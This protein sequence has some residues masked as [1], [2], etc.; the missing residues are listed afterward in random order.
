[1]LLPRKTQKKWTQFSSLPFSVITS[2]IISNLSEGF[3]F[4]SFE[5]KGLLSEK[6]SKI[7]Y[8][9]NKRISLLY[10]NQ[11]IRNDPKRLDEFNT[12]P[13]LMILFKAHLIR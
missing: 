4:H 10:S 11:E 1:M 12:Q 9:K 2:L 3:S 13:A 7:T 6:F 5:L 8:P